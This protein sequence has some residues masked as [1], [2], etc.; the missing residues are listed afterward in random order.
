MKQ[1]KHN[2]KAIKTLGA[3][4]NPDPVWVASSRA[5]LLQ[6][7]SNTRIPVEKPVAVDTVHAFWFQVRS[8]SFVRTMRPALTA[9]SV[10]VIATGGWIASVSASVNSLPGDRLWIVKR[11]AQNTEIAVKSL[12]ASDTEKMQLKLRLAK[13]RVDDIKKTYT[14]KLNTVAASSDRTKTIKDLN[15]AVHDIQ[16]AAREVSTSITDQVKETTKEKPL[17]VVETVKTVA[18]DTAELAKGLASTVSASNSSDVEITKQVLET[19]KVVNQTGINAVEAVVQQQ[20]ELAKSGE[21]NNVK[22]IVSEK[23]VDL[24][25]S[26]EAIKNDLKTTLGVNSVASKTVPQNDSLK[27]TVPTATGTALITLP[28]IE[29]KPE[30]FDKSV[31]ETSNTSVQVIKDAEQKTQDIHQSAVEIKKNID[32]GNLQEAVNILKTLNE[33]A[34]TTQ[35]EL[36]E[37]RSKSVPVTVPVTSPSTTV[38]TTTTVK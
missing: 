35:Q 25:Q 6:Q 27:L 10:A 7:I 14:K 28:L 24:V 2:L 8:S 29:S 11:V 20:T 9:L 22:N 18:R 30:M 33:T 38:D 23:V 4:I 1:L 21:T 32:N 3:G 16:A 26:T 12:G 36:V 17:E 15:V 34:V 31:S 19:V 37:T 13:S 5:R